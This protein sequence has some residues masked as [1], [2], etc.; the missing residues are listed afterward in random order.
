MKILG[1][2]GSSRKNGNTSILINQNLAPFKN[3]DKFEIETL[4]PGDLDIEGCRAC[5]RNKTSSYS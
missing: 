1:I 4:F 5:D 3:Q 2:F